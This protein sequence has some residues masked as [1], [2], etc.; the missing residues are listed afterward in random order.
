MFLFGQNCTLTL[1][2][3]GEINKEPKRKFLKWHIGYLLKAINPICLGTDLTPAL[4]PYL[5]RVLNVAKERL[6]EDG[7]R[8]GIFWIVEAGD[9]QRHDHYLESVRFTKY[10]N[11]L[12][13]WIKWPEGAYNILLNLTEDFQQ[14]NH[15]SKDNFWEWAVSFPRD[16]GKG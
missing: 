10:S 3:D 13:S 15:L 11:V 9:G 7:S 5:C 16:F 1:Y 14:L 8:K 4:L 6:I 2:V 12:F